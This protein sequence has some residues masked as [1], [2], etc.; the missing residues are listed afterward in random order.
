MPDECNP[1]MTDR[2]KPGVAI[3]GTVALVVALVGYPLGEPAAFWLVCQEWNPRWMTDV[4]YWI[5]A[6]MFRLSENGPY[7]IANAIRRFLSF[8]H[9]DAVD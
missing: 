4:F 6:P 2:K 5:Y 8:W 9:G 3:W 1:P 7:P